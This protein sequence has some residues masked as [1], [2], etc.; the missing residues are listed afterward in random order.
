[1]KSRSLLRGWILALGGL[2]ALVPLSL[3][4]LA[5]RTMHK[6]RIAFRK[7]LLDANEESAVQ[8]AEGDVEGEIG[9]FTVQEMAL[10]VRVLLTTTGLRGRLTS[11]VIIMGHG[12]FSSNNPYRSAYD[13]GACGGRP[14]RLNSRVFALMAN[15]IEVR[16]YL[17]NEG[18]VIPSTTH[19][20]GAYHNTCTDE[21]EYFEQTSIPETHLRLFHQVRNDIDKARALNAFER[22]RR[23]DDVSIR[24]VDKA[25][26]HVESRAHHIAQ[27]RPE[28]GHA[29]NA[30]CVIGKREI[31]QGLFLDRRAFLVSYDNSG[32]LTGETLQNLLRAVIPVCMGINLEYFFSSLDNQVYGA[33]SK[34]PHNVTSLLGLMT[35]YCSDLRTGLPAQMVEIH[36]PVR[37]L[38]VIQREPHELLEIIQREAPLEKIIKNG[39]IQLMAYS[40]ENNCL[41]FYNSDGVFEE[42]R[43]VPSVLERAQ[44]SKDWVDGKTNHLEFVQISGN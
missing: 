8:F 34:L 18:F 15:R 24:D 25:L 19:F 22:C 37:L 7:R 13:C 36:E 5:P 29:T 4:T 11:L 38:V 17:A 32:D 30:I 2:L 40:A 6:L 26:A 27:P 3:S 10:R 28:Y 1:M 12:S 39:W 21:V 44:C 35:G 20:I 9:G 43:D 41:H 42:Y 14:G 33:G 23:F 31:T 16:Q